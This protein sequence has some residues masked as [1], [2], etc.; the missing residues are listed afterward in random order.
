[1]V[2]NKGYIWY[3]I[4]LLNYSMQNHHIAKQSAKYEGALRQIFIVYKVPIE[5]LYEYR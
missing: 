1:M 3:E 4:S 5:G 2:I